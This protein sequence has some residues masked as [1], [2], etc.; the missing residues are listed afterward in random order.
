MHREAVM[1]VVLKD[2]VLVVVFGVAE[3]AFTL[4]RA[5]RIPVET[6]S[7]VQVVAPLSGTRGIRHFGVTV[8]GLLKVGR[9]G[10]GPGV[11]QLVAV[12]RGVPALRI[13]LAQPARH[14]FDELLISDPGAPEMEKALSSA[15]V[16][17]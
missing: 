13:T 17:R 8:L 2:D 10:L 4:R 16:G 1:T 11:R 3:R 6:I 7:E 9:W 5:V 14:G 15:R 12:R